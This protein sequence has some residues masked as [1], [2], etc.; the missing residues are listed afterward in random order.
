MRIYDIH[1]LIEHK[2]DP[3]RNGRIYSCPRTTNSLSNTISAGYR[4]RSLQL[5]FHDADAGYGKRNT[6]QTSETDKA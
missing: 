2:S 1:S 6:I 4:V 5:Q 3:Y